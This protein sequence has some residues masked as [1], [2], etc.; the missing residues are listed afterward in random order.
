M[1]R[2]LVRPEGCTCLVNRFTGRQLMKHDEELL[3]L[4]EQEEAL[5]C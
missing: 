3:L 1:R 2:N 5:R 4:S